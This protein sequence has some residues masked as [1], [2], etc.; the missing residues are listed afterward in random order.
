MYKRQVIKGKLSFTDFEFGQTAVTMVGT[1]KAEER[2]TEM[3]SK[4]DV[5]TVKSFKSAKSN[6]GRKISSIS[7]VKKGAYKDVFVLWKGILNE[8]MKKFR[9]PAVIDERRKAHF[10]EKVM[11]NVPTLTEEED[12]ML[13]SVAGL[14][15][16]L[17]KKGKR[18]KGTLK[19]G[20]D[21]FLWREG[22]KVWAAFGVT[23]DK[24][25]KG[26]LAEQFL[27]D[28]FARSKKH[29]KNNGN[30]PRVMR[31]DVDGTRSLHQHFGVKVP[32]ATNRLLE[33]WYVWKEVK[34]ENGRT[35]YMLAFV[36]L[37]EYP[38]GG[39]KDLSKEGFVLA[40]T[41][42]VYFFN[43]IAPNVCRVTRIPVSYTH[44][45]LPTKA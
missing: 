3:K 42:G 25:A 43:E 26:V 24:S 45:T 5:R 7:S 28:T 38:G 14:E 6:I 39:F 33:N 34:L 13:E 15:E 1:L 29:F 23:V 36:P 16:E 20:I 44:L 19:E 4:V 41:T 21:K 22:D 17:Y 31:K 32:A 18:V 35:S 2:A 9:Q 27:L 40:E 37:T 10:V 12:R 30:L 8:V 11:P